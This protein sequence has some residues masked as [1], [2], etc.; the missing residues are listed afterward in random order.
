MSPGSVYLLHI[1]PGLPITGNRVAR[2]YIGWTSG[3]V[4]D[5]LA[6][7]VAGRGSPLIRAALV[8]GSTVTV[9]RVWT[10][11]DRN[12]ERSLKRRK[13]APRMC[14]LCVGAGATRGRALLGPSA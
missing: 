9:E 6:E 8:A 7:H 13:E 10:D 3:P 11:R 4:E 5:R 1:E 2:H 12:F 14:P